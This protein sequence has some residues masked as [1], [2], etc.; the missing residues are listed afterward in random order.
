MESLQAKDLYAHALAMEK[1]AAERYAEFATRMADEGNEEVARLFSAL[2][3]QEEEHY[4]A[5]LRRA[6][7]AGPLPLE[8]YR[9]L[10]SGSP[11]TAAHDLI[12]RLLT[13]RQ[14][15]AIALA[16]ERRARDFFAVASGAAA[17]GEARA[18]A[19]EFAA[20]E[21]RHIAALLAALERTPP[22]PDW[23]RLLGPAH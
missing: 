8:R 5:L 12:F 6:P 9:W 22:A 19:R 3:S 7:S 4:R 16:A 20:E 11:E 23:E 21:D 13:P 10:D 15:L 14:A 17:D 18:L 1:E 2:A